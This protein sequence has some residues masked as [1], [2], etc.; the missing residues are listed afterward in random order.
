MKKTLL[1]LVCLLTVPIASASLHE[2]SSI[3]STVTLSNTIELRQTGDI[4]FDFLEVNYSWVPQTTY[5]QTINDIRTSPRTTVGETIMYRYDRYQNSLPYSVTID[6]ITQGERAEIKEKIPFPIQEVDPEKREYLGSSGLID[7]TPEI[8]RKADEIAGDEDDLYKVSVKIAD[9]V[10][11]NI[12]YN[13]STLSEDADKESSWVLRNRRGVCTELSNLYIS[14][15]RS[16]GVPA[17]FVTGVSYT[18]SDLFQERWGLHGWTEVYFPNHG[19]VPVDPTYGQTGYVDA[20]H[21]TLDKSRG[22]DLQD[23]TFRWKG[24]GFEVRPG[25]TQ[26]DVD[27]T[28]LGKK[29]G[30]VSLDATFQ[31]D[32][33]GFGSYNT[34]RV[35]VTNT[36]D[37][38]VSER[39][40]VG[41]TQGIDYLVDRQ[42]EIVLEPSTSKTYEFPLKIVGDQER[43][44]RYTYPI[45]IFVGNTNKSESFTSL[46]Q[47]DILPKP[48]VVQDSEKTF[49]CSTSTQTVRVGDTITIECETSTSDT[50]NICIEDRCVQKAE[51][52]FNITHNVSKPGL[53]TLTVQGGEQ[54]SYVSINALDETIVSYENITY[55]Q[56]PEYDDMIQMKIFLKKQS[57]SLPSNTTVTITHPYY[58]K[59][60]TIG[61]LNNK[62]EINY[63]IPA[64]S[65]HPG[66]NTFKLS[67]KYRDD[68]GKQY[69]QTK[70]ID[71]NMENL[72]LWQQLKLYLNAIQ[73]WIQ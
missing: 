49:F 35:N 19:W 46:G 11:R 52:T 16:L 22:G 47:G 36:E 50:L 4:T 15:M 62:Q 3:D 13:L 2:S 59:T 73:R 12:Q 28:S 70:Q 21:I 55:D 53:R 68:L 66:K 6:V 67:T 45:N 29:Q 58:E 10:N 44:F 33:V 23:T 24:S 71:I 56:T 69:E 27:A 54:K 60:F 51:D 61:D 14:M 64:S 38:Y 18:E 7:I 65:L 1:V 20:T 39:L 43:G 37:H 32:Q 42:N 48:D 26:L 31:Q 57:V 63:N 30:D 17:R 41:E 9:W 25:E 72:S 5:R 40:I 8:K 34:L